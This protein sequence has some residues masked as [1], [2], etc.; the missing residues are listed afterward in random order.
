M[1]D[2]DS[3]IEELGN[4]EKSISDTEDSKIMLDI[5]YYMPNVS[6]LIL[7]N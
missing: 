4:K 2:T 6:L 3:F 1:S 5:V 7:K